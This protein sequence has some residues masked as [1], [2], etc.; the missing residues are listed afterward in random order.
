MSAT[1]VRCYMS[2]LWIQTDSTCDNTINTLKRIY[3]Q[4]E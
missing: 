4:T 3:G 1:K 2:W